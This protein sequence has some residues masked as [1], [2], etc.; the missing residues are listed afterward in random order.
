MDEIDLN[1]VKL[2]KAQSTFVHKGRQMHCGRMLTLTTRSLNS[3][4]SAALPLWRSLCEGA[5]KVKHRVALPVLCT[6]ASELPGSITGGF[7][8]GGV[9]WECQ[10]WSTV[11]CFFTSLG[12]KFMSGAER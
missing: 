9:V 11:S 5:S 12:Y 2:R 7:H 10:S 1:V 6:P 4:R 8:Q 3:L